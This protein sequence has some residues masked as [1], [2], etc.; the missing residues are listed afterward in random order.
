LHLSRFPISLE[1][2]PVDRRVDAQ[3]SFVLGLDVGLTMDR[4]T[5][6]LL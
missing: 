1:R 5:N 2:G 6:Y 4:L 3:R